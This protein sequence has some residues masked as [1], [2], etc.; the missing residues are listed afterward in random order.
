M[1]DKLIDEKINIQIK[2]DSKK[3]HL[4]SLNLN[5]F[6]DK[7]FQ[8][9]D[10][11]ILSLAN[12]LL[13]ELPSDIKKL[14]K[15]EKLS[16]EGNNIKSL[17]REFSELKNLTT[18]CLGFSKFESIPKEIF[19]LKNLR[20]LYIQYN[21]IDEIPSDIKRLIHLKE[22]NIRGNN[23]REIPSDIAELDKMKV[24]N[25]GRNKI[26]KL[27]QEIS[28]LHNL[29][30]LYLDYS[31][32]HS[33]PDEIYNINSLTILSFE[34]NNIIEIAPKIKKLSNLRILILN[35]NK[36]SQIPCEI[37]WLHNLRNLE[38]NNNKLASLP[39]DLRYLSNLKKLMLG[40]NCYEKFPKI[41]NQLTKLR[42][43]DLS[44]NMIKQLPKDIENLNLENL[45]LSRNK[46]A[47]LSP[48]IT[49][50]SNLKHIDLT[51]NPMDKPPIEIC[52]RGLESIKQYYKDLEDQGEDYI[53]EAKLVLVGEP[54]AGKTTLVEKLRNPNYQLNP[55]EP[56]T[57]GID[58][59]KWHFPFSDNIN[60]TSNIWDFGGQEIMHATHRYFLTK[61]SLYI[62]LADNRRED[63]DFYYWL[64]MIELFSSKSPVLIVLNEK[65]NYKK[66]IS[67]DIRK[68]FECVKDVCNINLA[69]NS[70]LSNLT[71]V[72]KNFMRGLPHVGKEPIPKKWVEIR[73][74][75]ENKKKDYISK[76][77]Y[78]DICRNCGI[79]D[80]IQ[81]LRIS[82]FLHDLGVILHFQ[83][84][85][86]LRNTVILNTS[87]ATEAV[88]LI[89]FDESVIKNNGEFGYNELDRIWNLQEYG[90]KQ[91]DLLQLMINFELCYK[92]ID[93]QKYIIPQLL[94]ER[95]KKY[96]WD[97]KENLFFE[98]RYTFM[99][100][101]IISRIIVRMNRYI[102]NQ[103][104][105]KSGVILKIEDAKAEIKEDFFQKVLKIR[106]SG[107]DKKECLAI[108]RKEISEIHA[109]FGAENF[110]NE[111]IPCNCDECKKS[112]SPHF[113]KYNVLNKFYQKGKLSISCENSTI[114][115]SV[116]E[117]LSGV[118]DY[119][120]NNTLENIGN[121]K[122]ELFERVIEKL[123]QLIFPSTTIEKDKQ[124]KKDTDNNKEGYEYDFIIRNHL[125]K[126][127]IIIEVKGYKQKKEINLGDS[128]TKETV[129]WFFCRTFPFAKNMLSS[130]DNYAIKACY[131]TWA[132]FS[133]E[134]L[135][136]LENLN[137]SKLKSSSLDVYYDNS[138][139]IELLRDKGLHQEIKLL[140]KYFS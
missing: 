48:N 21:S 12:S 127:I 105:W 94:P 112:R 42:L 35:S 102:L 55:T 126:E 134:S 63:T 95:S 92:F 11:R 120:I 104:Q 140:R 31:S 46:I 27:P 45:N 69:E 103:L 76:I 130:H 91:A 14:K 6:P 39:K 43:L 88:Y 111:M 62:L 75:L 4:E 115:V 100:K 50:I 118:N 23:I 51:G 57:K 106:I 53:Y 13:T 116:K 122:G 93:E 135:A 131:M 80:E 9:E 90:D 59:T 68:S 8:F 129:K 86:L 5:S 25:L 99:P 133:S 15:L 20:F 101:G 29:N 22:L 7:I 89:L 83:K 66:Y 24:L 32:L 71:T 110:V 78:F 16:L 119:D 138:K 58:V 67:D 19:E 52:S 40:S 34:N 87:W 26:T 44:N 79:N 38:L 139:L 108:I 2:G 17:P 61:R 37:G 30:A 56:M 136:F 117:L 114:D 96:E 123:L 124:L 41:L 36:I 10:L 132:N 98:Y 113:F 82:E 70:G 28:N 65:Y 73:K 60:F 64:K 128:D 77:E 47:K 1:D 54:G 97:D 72:I 3:I 137:N 84:D 125:K 18:L 109:T 33:I 121:I 85:I 49:K 74:E 107:E 81:S